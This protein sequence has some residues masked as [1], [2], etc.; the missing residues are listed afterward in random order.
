MS[1]KSGKSK[2]V[3]GE[4]DDYYEESVGNS[5]AAYGWT[6]YTSTSPAEAGLPRRLN[7]RGESMDVTVMPA[8]GGGGS[9][10]ASATQPPG[11]GAG[12]RPATGGGGSASAS[13]T[14][15]PGAGG[16]QATGASD[17]DLDN[18][19]DLDNFNRLRNS[20]QHLPRYEVVY[21]GPNST[22]APPNIGGMAEASAPATQSPDGGMA[23]AP[24]TQSPDD[25]MGE[26]SLPPA[27]GSSGET[28]PE[29]GPSDDKDKDED[30]RLP[31]GYCEEDFFCWCP[32]CRGRKRHAAPSIQ[33][34]AD[35]M[36]VDV[37][38]PDTEGSASASATE[39]E[40]KPATGG[41]ASA[42]ETKLA[43]GVPVLRLRGA[44]F[45]PNV[46]AEPEPETQDEPEAAPPLSEGDGR[47][48]QSAKAYSAPASFAAFE[49][50]VQ[51]YFG[52]Q[53]ELTGY[54]FTQVPYTGN[55]PVQ[56]G[57]RAVAHAGSAVAATQFAQDPPVATEDED[58]DSRRQALGTGD[59]DTPVPTE[60][61]DCSDLEFD[62]TTAASQPQAAPQADPQQ[63]QAVPSQPQAQ[64]APSEPQVMHMENQESEVID[65]P[66]DMEAE[67]DYDV[68]P[69]S[70]P[71]AEEESESSHV[72][73]VAST[74]NVVAMMD[75]AQDFRPTSPRGAEVAPPTSLGLSAHADVVINSTARALRSVFGGMNNHEFVDYF[76]RNNLTMPANSTIQATPPG[77]ETGHRPQVVLA[78][79]K[80]N[81]I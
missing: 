46:T 38:K 58:A 61:G 43:T 37:E 50:A 69:P 63:P 27:T 78:K 48:E 6:R 31:E 35:A 14:Q 3:S 73:V 18:L 9:A 32:E 41:V 79:K 53:S 56:V 68:D 11:R 45:L 44:R 51:P 52:V 77:L 66:L 49:S 28:L 7:H 25:G 24:A 29:D 22:T 30:L 71:Q 62:A 13:A 10:K 40:T 15:P 67:A 20:V 55:L 72:S 19:T 57:P 8:T 36:D 54:T 80:K 12:G 76:V 4:K 42:T 23:S 26:A 70:Q 47:S 16:R 34:K 1:S 60:P 75:D 64:A 2:P 65:C 74:D 21:R 81:K 59:G 17:L 39:T 5:S 33:S